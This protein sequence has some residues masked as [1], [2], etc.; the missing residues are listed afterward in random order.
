MELSINAQIEQEIL[1]LPK[2]R[3]AK[4]RKFMARYYSV[5]NLINVSKNHLHK[6]MMYRNVFLTEI[7]ERYKRGDMQFLSNNL[8]GYI[9]H[10]IKSV[11]AT[12]MKEYIRLKKRM[13]L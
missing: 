3:E 8:Y 9:R 4:V 1:Q 13:L 5:A 11:A 2:D 10:A 7:E 12:F 6:M